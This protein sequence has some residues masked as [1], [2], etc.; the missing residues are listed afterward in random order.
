MATVTYNYLDTHGVMMYML[1]SVFFTKNY[2]QALL[3]SQ[4][5]KHSFYWRMK[6]FLKQATY[7]RYVIPKLSKFVQISMLT[8]S[9][10]FFT[11]NSF[12]IKKD[13][14]LV[15]GPYFSHNLLMKNFI[16]YINWPN[17]ITR[18]CLVPKLFNKMCFVFHAF[19]LDDIMTFEYLKS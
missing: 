2:F 12:K 14:E 7:I 1:Q 19:A 16:F 10:S 17:F 15:S 5:I 4:R 11:E 8:S 9:D 13:L 3:C 18:W 6:K